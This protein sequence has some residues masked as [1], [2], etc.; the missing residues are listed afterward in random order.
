MKTEKVSVNLSPVELGQIDY[1]VE[2]GLYDSRS[3]FMRTAARKAL[4]SHESSI[5]EFFDAKPYEK[6]GAYH[7]FSFGIRSITKK[8]IEHAIKIGSKMQIH[9]IGMLTIPNS[10]TSEDIK[11]GVRSL[12]LYGKLIAS[13]EVKE[14][15]SELEE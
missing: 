7:T 8:E 12:K 3:D 10:I 1:L 15:L 13:K 2:R 11:Q 6:E 5:R 9:A 14:A 4:E